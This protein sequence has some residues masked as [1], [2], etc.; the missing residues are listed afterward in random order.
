[1]AEAQ[2]CIMC[3]KLTTRVPFENALVGT[4]I[5]SRRCELK[6]FESVR[7]KKKEQQILLRYLNKKIAKT[8]KYNQIG[9][10]GTTIGIVWTALGV[11]LAR[12][13]VTKDLEV[14][15]L[16]FLTGIFMTTC[17]ALSTCYFDDR[18]RRLAETRRK[19]V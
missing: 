9:W 2:P 16:I 14:A 15:V 12:F 19:L 8:K 6:Y 13:S 4:Y 3:G 18:K 17:G 5:C 10:A 1:M 7:H 11:I